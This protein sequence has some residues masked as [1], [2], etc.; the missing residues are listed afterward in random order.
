[1]AD[2][3]LCVDDVY[4]GYVAGLP[5]VGGVSLRV[6]PGEI[7]AL[8]GPNGA[9]KSTLVKA[10]AGTVPLFAGRISCAGMD[11]ARRKPWQIARAGVG[12]VPQL[13]NVFT[14][15][16]VA[17]NLAVGRPAGG[18][19]RGLQLEEMLALF[20][21]LAERR[22]AMVGTLSGGQ[23]Q[24]VAIGRA[25]LGGPAVLLLDEPSAG[26]A[27]KVVKELFAALAMLKRRV[28]ILL[29]EQNV[30]AAMAIADRAILLAEGRVRREATPAALLA[31]P[32]LA[33][34]FLGV[35]A[36]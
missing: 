2:A 14:D 29:V 25:L 15:M 8:F 32:A 3:V 6:W 35:M 27:P 17:E 33:S 31:D 12:Y 19:G 1:M 30:L 11:L 21:D 26:L 10:I 16:T 22:G 23:R 28:P 34:A 20:P 24:M 9:G 13:G 7:V 5:I 18:T 36:L 4:A